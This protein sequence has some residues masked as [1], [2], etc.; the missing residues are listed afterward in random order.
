MKKALIALV[1]TAI[2]GIL[3]VHFARNAILSG[4]SVDTKGATPDQQVTQSVTSNAQQSPSP[5]FSNDVQVVQI[6]YFDN[7]TWLVAMVNQKSAPGNIAYIIM[8]LVNGKYQ[9]VAG[10]G[11][12]FGG[13]LLPNNVPPDVQDYLNT[14]TGN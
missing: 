5:V 3:G 2:I 8:Q 4:A 1:I 11:T 13:N 12:D 7:K 14:E 9:T 6:Q 10:P